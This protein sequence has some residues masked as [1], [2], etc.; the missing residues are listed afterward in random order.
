ML[1]MVMVYAFEYSFAIIPI[2][3]VFSSLSSSRC[4]LFLCSLE[5]YETPNESS[6]CVLLFFPT[7]QRDFPHQIKSVFVCVR[8]CLRVYC[9][10]MKYSKVFIIC[11][12]SFCLVRTRR[13]NA[14]VEPRVR[15][16]V[17]D[18]RFWQQRCKISN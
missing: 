9:T 16:I 4:Y 17:C 6:V 11:Y 18:I 1:V 12:Q 14:S 7:C 15:N 13:D 2:F 8:V 3:T 10:I 5:V